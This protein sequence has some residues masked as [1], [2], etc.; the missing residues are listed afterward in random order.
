[1]DVSVVIPCRNN[2][3]SI[4]VQLA[5][6][7]RQDWYS[8]WE[9]VVADNGSTDGTL[10]V[11]EQ[12]RR[13]LPR[14]RIIDASRRRGAA[15]ARNAGVAAASGEAIL[16]CDA[17]DEVGAGWLSAMGEGLMRCDFVAARLETEKLNPPEIAAAVKNPQSEGLQR[18]SYPPQLW[19]ASG[20]TLGVKRK[21]H[22]RIGGFDET[23]PVLEDTDYCFRL[24]LG[25]VKLCFI[26]NA[27]VHY[28]FRLN[29]QA[30][31]QQARC[32]GQYNVLMYKRYGQNARLPRPWRR[33]LLRWHSLLRSVPALRDKDQRFAWT[34]GLGTQLGVLQGSIKY[35]VPPV[36]GIF[37]SAIG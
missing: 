26:E 19:H 22:D 17:D 10:E 30:L 29:H 36:A 34:K 9:V 23:L 18:V 3:A 35:G 12:H 24:Q 25:G 28:R 8:P 7:A 15:H 13:S 20:A 37:L 14:L 2:A 11:V 5:A 32:W 16:F 1:M 33:H 21:V 27:I 4:G 31:F 6:L